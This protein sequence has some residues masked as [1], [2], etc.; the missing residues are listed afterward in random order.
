MFS[1]KMSPN[2]RRLVTYLLFKS[3][4]GN[5]SILFNMCSFGNIFS[6]E[7]DTPWSSEL[8]KPN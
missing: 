2:C 4:W 6:Y 8:Y 3:G 7:R 5:R 1:S